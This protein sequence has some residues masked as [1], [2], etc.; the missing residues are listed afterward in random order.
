[1]RD[2]IEAAA[3]GAGAAARRSLAHAAESLVRAGGGASTQWEGAS[4]TTHFQP[5]YRVRR[6]ECFGFEALMRAKDAQGGPVLPEDMFARTAES[7]R[8]LLDWTCRAL[9]LRNYATV[10]PGD[11][12]LFINVDP[13]AIVRDAHQ[14][15]ELGDLIRYYGLVPKRV[16]LEVLEAPCADE[17]KLRDAVDS[18]RELGVCIAMDDFGVGCSNFDRVVALRPDLVK[19]D[20]SLLAGAL[21]NVRARRMLP[22]MIDLLHQA[23]VKVVVEG[24]E[25]REA[26]QLA[27]EARA[28]FLQGYYFAMPG[29]RL[30]GEGPG[31]ERLGQVLGA[32]GGA[33]LAA[34]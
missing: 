3:G 19:V 10:D 27:I 29:A 21:G 25:S 7:A 22:G 11:R 17:R 28:D 1:M 31:I 12:M 20:R 2:R 32:P 34:V 14:A 23:Q 8:T 6:P 13:G 18:Y 16:C 26:A 24:I 9:H 30:A 15:R 5:I 4:L 33:K